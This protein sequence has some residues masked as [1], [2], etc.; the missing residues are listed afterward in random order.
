M[1]TWSLFCQF[2]PFPYSNTLTW[3]SCASKSL[4][5]FMGFT[6]KN[7][8]GTLPISDHQD[9]SIS[10]PPGIYYQWPTRKLL[11]VTSI[12]KHPG[13]SLCHV[14]K[15]THCIARCFCYYLAPTSHHTKSSLNFRPHYPGK[16]FT[17]QSPRCCPSAGFLNWAQQRTIWEVLA[18]HRA[19]THIWDYCVC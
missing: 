2:H 14:W 3:S 17:S 12:S 18:E 6:P 13:L 5:F 15:K 10:D 11:S 1:T 19:H 16:P 4:T 8:Q 9:C 7:C